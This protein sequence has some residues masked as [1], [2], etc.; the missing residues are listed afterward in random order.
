MASLNGLDARVES[1][2]IQWVTIDRRVEHNESGAIQPCLYQLAPN[3]GLVSA[4]I[5]GKTPDG[6]PVGNCYECKSNVLNRRC[7]D[8]RVISPLSSDMRHEP[9]VYDE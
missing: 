9:Y 3:E 7:G 5:M 2:P 4:H 8:Y 1:A 6:R